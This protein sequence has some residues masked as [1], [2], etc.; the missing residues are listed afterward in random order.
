MN[1]VSEARVS[2]RRLSNASSSG[3][4]KGARYAAVLW[5]KPERSGV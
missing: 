1:R 2:S 3:T 4:V 5:K